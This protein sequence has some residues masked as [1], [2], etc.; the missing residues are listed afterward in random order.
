MLTCRVSWVLDMAR[1]SRC[2]KP[3]A[4]VEKLRGYARETCLAGRGMPA[5]Q[6]GVGCSCGFVGN[7]DGQAPQHV[8]DHGQRRDQ[9]RWRRGAEKR[10]MVGRKRLDADASHVQVPVIRMSVWMRMARVARQETCGQGERAEEQRNANPPQKSDI[11]DGFA[12]QAGGRFKCHSV[13]GANCI[14]SVNLRGKSA[15]LSR[16]RACATC[17]DAAA[18]ASLPLRMA[19]KYICAV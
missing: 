16:G 7:R 15:W 5:A 10:L 11:E 17:Q 2:L 1:V 18:S 3:S 4:N 19:G 9:R 8:P 12:V 14:K 13:V 6:F